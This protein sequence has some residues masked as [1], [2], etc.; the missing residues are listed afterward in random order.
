VTC[1][2]TRAAELALRLKYAGLAVERIDV[3]PKLS[4]ALDVALS[5]HPERLFVLPT[6][7]A[8]LE[9]QEELT[10]RGHLAGS[11]SSR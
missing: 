6:Y 11:W 3:V 8:L 7:T 10:A 5:G 4:E 2:G 1:A 9:L